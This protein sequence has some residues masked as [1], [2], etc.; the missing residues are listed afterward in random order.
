MGVTARFFFKEDIMSYFTKTE[1]GIWL[2]SCILILLS[3]LCFD[4]ESYVSLI[5]SLIGVTSLI[6]CAKGNP[7]GQILIIIFSLLYGA[8]SYSYRYYGEMATY[9]GMT[10]PM[11]IVAL[12]EWIRHPYKGDKSE[13]EVRKITVADHIFMW[14]LTVAVTVVFYFILRYFN[15]ANLLVSTFSVATSFAAVYL[16]SRRS[17]YY[18]VAYAFNDIVLIVLWTMA[19]LE[20]TRYVS[21]VA[22]FAAFLVNDIYG[23]INW[24]RMEK[25]QNLC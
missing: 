13:V 2:G 20:N 5:A 22:C 11:A 14:V 8:I 21:V 9:V 7:F 6:F 19:S 24:R 15:T 4:R 16:T 25:R 12:V 1:K 3:F 18:A 10:L 23:F 17:P